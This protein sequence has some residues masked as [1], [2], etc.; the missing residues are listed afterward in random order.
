[1]KKGSVVLIPF[2]FTDLRGSKIRPAVVLCTGGLDV[3]ICFITSELRWKTESDISIFPSTNNGLKTPSLIRIA[4]IATIDSNL[5]LG[6]LGELSND[7]IAEL[8]KGLI[9]LFQLI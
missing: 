6:E 4:K 3:T 7:E 2:P 1:M 9:K 5:A 8:N